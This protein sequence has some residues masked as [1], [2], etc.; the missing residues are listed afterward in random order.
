VPRG[1]VTVMY[2]EKQV[3]YF[4]PATTTAKVTL[5]ASTVPLGAMPYSSFPV[6]VYLSSWTA[7]RRPRRRDGDPGWRVGGVAGDD[8][9]AYGSSTKG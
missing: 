4:A 2:V 1:A 5:P 9:P 3:V 7:S 6:T 8:L